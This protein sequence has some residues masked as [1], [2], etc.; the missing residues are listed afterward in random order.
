MEGDKAIAG[1]LASGLEREAAAELHVCVE[2]E[3]V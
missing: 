1:V 2:V 3:G